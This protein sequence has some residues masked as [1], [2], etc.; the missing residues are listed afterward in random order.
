MGWFQV[1]TYHFCPIHKLCNFIRSLHY[2]IA[3]GPWVSA[4]L[5]HSQYPKHLPCTFCPLW[6][7]FS[8]WL[9]MTWKF[10]CNL[11][12]LLCWP[13][14]PN[15]LYP[16]LLWVFCLFQRQRSDW[17][18]WSFCQFVCLSSFSLTLVIWYFQHRVHILLIFQCN[19]LSWLQHSDVQCQD[20]WLVFHFLRKGLQFA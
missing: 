16:I 15:L 7:E 1:E 3:T 5:S 18:H 17:L 2:I 12:I 8:Q 10:W 20:V 4:E 6:E 14:R 9:F 13:I 11:R 19:K